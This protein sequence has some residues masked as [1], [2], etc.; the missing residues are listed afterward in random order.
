MSGLHT[1]QPAS[2][3]PAGCV[4]VCAFGFV[5][6]GVSR[7]FRGLA[8]SDTLSCQ[9]SYYSHCLI[10]PSALIFCSSMNSEY[11]RAFSHTPFSNPFPTTHTYHTPIMLKFLT[12]IWW[13]NVYFVGRLG[14]ITIATTEQKIINKQQ[15]TDKTK[16]EQNK[17]NKTNCFLHSFTLCYLSPRV[18]FFVS[19]VMNV[20]SKLRNQS[21]KKP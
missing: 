10:N 21:L 19:L 14:Q 6:V 9:P 15:S 1:E 3:S 16:Q 8:A 17:Q 12:P 18:V 20:R 7:S 5:C 13:S 4:C 11:H 2:F